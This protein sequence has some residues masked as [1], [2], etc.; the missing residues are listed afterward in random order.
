MFLPKQ[1]ATSIK[2]QQGLVPVWGRALAGLE[3]LLPTF[4][5]LLCLACKEEGAHG[6][7]LSEVGAIGTQS[8]SGTPGLDDLKHLYLF[9]ECRYLIHVISFHILGFE[10]EQPPLSAGVMTHF[11]SPCTAHPQKVVT[12]R[13]PALSCLFFSFM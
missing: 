1:D 8:S 9:Y 12:E 6:T 7:Y 5:A 10:P 4:V 13:I 3:M 2:W 11:P